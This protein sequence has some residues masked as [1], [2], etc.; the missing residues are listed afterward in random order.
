MNLNPIPQ[1]KKYDF[2]R[3]RV[4]D[5]NGNIFKGVRLDYVEKNWI[6]YVVPDMKRIISALLIT[7]IPPKE[8]NIPVKVKSIIAKKPHDLRLYM[9]MLNLRTELALL[10]GIQPK[11]FKPYDTLKDKGQGILGMIKK[12]IGQ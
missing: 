5:N 9:G 2:P 6:V 11:Y 8:P 7:C 4:K 10:K 3:L 1:L 12:Y